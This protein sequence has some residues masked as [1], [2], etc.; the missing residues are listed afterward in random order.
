MLSG[1][2]PTVGQEGTKP[3]CVMPSKPLPAVGA[4]SAMPVLPAGNGGAVVSNVNFA[5]D[6]GVSPGGWAFNCA[7]WA[8]SSGERCDFGVATGADASGAR[9]GSSENTNVVGVTTSAD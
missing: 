3:C 1:P 8:A 7:S 5:N 9:C 4:T 6:V 2:A